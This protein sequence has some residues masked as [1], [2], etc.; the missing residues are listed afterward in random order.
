MADQHANLL[1]EYLAGSEAAA[2]KVSALSESDPEACWRFLEEARVADLSDNELAFL[3]AGP[4]EDL[5]GSHG[6]VFLDRLAVA[7]RQD[8]AMRYLLATVWRG[9]MSKP[10]WDRV[11]AIKQSL[12]I[13]SD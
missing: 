13:T 10:V 5:M 6:E 4:F 1:K 2:E 3:S 9:G 11:T 7:A 8:K 12:G